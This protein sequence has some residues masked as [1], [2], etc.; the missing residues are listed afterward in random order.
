[1]NEIVVITET[2][3]KALVAI[4]DDWR[5][6]YSS[7]ACSPFL[8]WEWMAT[9]FEYFGKGK[10]VFLIKV[11][12]DGTLIGILPMFREANSIL[13]F[14]ADRLCLMG[15]GPGGAD[16]LD[17]I[18]RPDDRSDAFSAVLAFLADEPGIDTIRLANLAAASPAI[19]LCEEFSHVHGAE[20]SRH[21]QTVSAIVPQIDLSGGWDAVLAASK[22]AS[23]FKRR[24]KQLEKM[25]AFE[26]RSITEPHEALSAF[27]RFLDLHQQRWAASGGSELSGHP[28]LIAFQRA[29]VPRLAEAGLIR[30][31]ELWVD[32]ACRSSVYGLDDRSTFYYYNSGYDLD[33][34]SQ[35]VGLVLLGLS[36]KSSIARGN[37]IYDFLRG[38][39]GYKF[40]WANRSGELV[41]IILSKPSLVSAASAGVASIMSGL[42]RIGKS[43][44]PERLATTIADRRR[45]WKRNYQLTGE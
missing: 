13:G 32:G 28:R 33:Y 34:A 16:H 45:A 14:G 22:R 29:L 43:A 27:E 30:F 4:R 39:E 21:S 11:L 24:L 20:F 37:R 12:R 19:G 23:N 17:M 25:S 40:D 44:L 18:C 42:R 5:L 6:L 36:I 9:W 2:S 3:E 35:S 8:S 10:Q 1:M 15:E 26:F 7:A 31:D 41:D 38:D